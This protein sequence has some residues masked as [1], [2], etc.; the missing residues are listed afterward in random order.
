MVSLLITVNIQSR[1]SIAE[2][3]KNGNDSSQDTNQNYLNQANTT[4]QN[5][6]LCVTGVAKG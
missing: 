2:C 4:L 6:G 1:R 5:A 3:Q